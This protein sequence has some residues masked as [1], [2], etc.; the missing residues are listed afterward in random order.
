MTDP[1]FQSPA[2]TLD[3]RRFNVVET[4][5]SGV[6]G[7]DTIFRFRQSQDMISADY[8]GG[9]IRQGRLIGRLDGAELIFCFCQMQNDGLMDNGQSRCSLERLPDGRLRMTERFEWGSRPGEAGVNVFEELP[10]A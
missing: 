10:E 8:S 1:T 2:I 7:R 4:A 9:K 5:G 6:V 3:G